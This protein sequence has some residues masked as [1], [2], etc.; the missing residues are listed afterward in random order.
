[1]FNLNMSVN[2]YLLSIAIAVLLYCIMLRFRRDSPKQSKALPCEKGLPL[3]GVVLK[4]STF[5]E[6]AMEKWGKKHGP[7]FAIRVGW[8][9]VVVIGSQEVA[10]EA[11]AKN[12]CFNDR[13]QSIPLISDG[14]GIVLINST[15]FHREQRRFGLFTLREF[16]MGRKSLE[17][18]LIDTSYDLCDTIASMCTSKTGS[19]DPF[20]LH[21]YISTTVSSVISRMV[22]GHVIGTENKQLQ[23]FFARLQNPEIRKASS[24]LRGATMFAPFLRHLPY[25]KGQ[26]E[27]GIQFQHLCHDGIKAEILDH[28]RSRDPHNPRDFID[29]FLNEME[30]SDSAANPDS[31]STWKHSVM[32]SDEVQECS[33]DWKAFSSFH[34]NQLV[35]IVRDLFLA[36]SE[37]TATSLSWIVLYLCKYQGVQKKMQDEIDDVI[38]QSGIPKMGLMDKMPYVRSVIQEITRLRPI[39]PLNVPHKASRDATLMGYHIP[40]DSII[41]TNIW[42]IHHDESK[43]P[44]PDE[45]LPERHLDKNGKFI[46]SPDWILFGVGHRSCLGQQLAK[47]ELFIMT[48]ALF[49][50]FN[51]TL[52]PGENPDM[53]G[54]SIITLH[55]HYYDVVATK[56]Y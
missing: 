25:F 3:L 23:E 11:F 2:P 53:K 50:R 45:F 54:R 24:F 27:K 8:M 17:P 51:F 56:R 36:G 37:T 44:K 13:P 40:K 39:A 42:A 31:A 21:T 41:L 29:C 1:M 9:N 38:G 48:V 4:V 30:K 18:Q 14:N 15:D 32:S 26:W 55:T 35:A 20:P 10:Y 46:K 52:A 34:I 28:Q 49:Q 16:G 5:P 47:M 19:S 6:R 33:S 12:D 43:W 22:F 7:L